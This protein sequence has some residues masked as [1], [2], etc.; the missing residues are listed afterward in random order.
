MKVRFKNPPINELVIGAYFDPPLRSLRS[1][2]MGLLWSRLRDDFP[3]VQQQGPL[4]GPGTGRDAIEMLSD[5][6]F[7][8]PR[9]WFISEDE[10]NLIQVQK[11]AFLFNW[12]KRETE[13]P[14]FA[15]HLKPRFD[16][17]YD[18]FEEF[19]RE[20]VG[21]E[22][23]RVGRC[24][25]AYIDLI[26]SCDYWKRPE[27]TPNLIPSFSVPDFGKAPA[28]SCSYRFEPM[29][30]VQLQVSLRVAEAVGDP[31]SPLLILEF[32]AVGHMASAPKSSVWKWYEHA[33]DAI[34][35]CFLEITSKEIQ[36]RYWMPEEQS[37]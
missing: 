20:D 34:G 31:S 4:G 2:H 6:V 33:H 7:P 37:E 13:Y 27:D 30:N 1:E 14:H 28:F 9:F 29:P 8:M 26:R 32:K 10:V 15:E 18:I 22:D 25:L 16:K 23:I 24:E 12:R 19:A 17:Y 35:T 11:D 36:R 5:E 21:L 3:T